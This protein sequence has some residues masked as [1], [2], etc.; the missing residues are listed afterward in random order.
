MVKDSD[1]YDKLSEIDPILKAKILETQ[2]CPKC[3]TT[4]LARDYE[5]IEI[6]CMNC[7]FVINQK[8]VEKISKNI[9]TKEKQN[10]KHTQDSALLTFTI[11]NKGLIR[12]VDW[13]RRD[14]HNKN[15]S[16]GQKTQGYRLRNWQRR[17]RITGSTERNLTFALSE[18]AKTASKLDLHKNVLETA[19]AI[20]RKAV[21]AHLINGHSIQ[22]I[23]IASLY[24]AIRQHEQPITL[25]ELAYVSA[26]NKKE[27]GKSYR[28][29]TKKLDQT[30]PPL[31]P[32]QCITN[33][34]SKLTSQKEVEEISHKIFTAAKDSKLTAGRSPT[35]IAAAASYISLIVLNEYKTQKEI[36]DI[37]QIT[38]ITIRNRYKELVDRL[39]FE[40]S[41]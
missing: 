39:M 41:V 6:A 26:V 34:S 36:A 22:G 27:L 19:T 14:S 29:L 38:E 31:Q 13:H 5:S 15:I 35:G 17:I 7:D 8:N 24:L 37:T 12:V 23:S 11:H 25:N 1:D 32:D 4:R 40:I 30:I 3:N 28:L 9:V 20:Y 18:I 21:E 16:F 33:F 2:K 10:A